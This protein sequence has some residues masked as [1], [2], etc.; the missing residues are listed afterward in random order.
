[1]GQSFKLVPKFDNNIMAIYLVL[2]NGDSRQIL[3]CIFP[4][5]KQMGDN[6]KAG[7]EMVA[8]LRKRINRSLN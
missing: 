6:V 1:M 8:T 2:P 5:D 7:E 3:Q 4:N